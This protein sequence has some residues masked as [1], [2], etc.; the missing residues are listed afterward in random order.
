[1]TEKEIPNPLDSSA[2][3][4]DSNEPLLLC[5]TQI[6]K[7]FDCQRGLLPIL[8]LDMNSSKKNSPP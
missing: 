3:S 4:A 5:Y 6:L 1:M 2:D 7:L 8:S